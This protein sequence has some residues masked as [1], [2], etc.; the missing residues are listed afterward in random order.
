MRKKLKTTNWPRPVIQWGV[1]LFVLI[2]AFIPKFN[3]NF[4]PDFEAYCPFGGIQALGSYMLNQ[5]LSCTMT[6]AQ[7][8]MGLI[9][10]LA[11]LV[12]SKLF[13]AYVCPV[14]TISEW[15]TQLG[16][17]LNVNIT[18]KGVADKILRSLKYI[19]LF[20]TVYFTFKSNEL[21]CKKFDPYY[22]VSTGFSADVVVLYASIAIF[23]VILGSVFVRLFW[24]K[25][26][27]PFGAISNIFKFTGFFLIVLIG[28]ILLLKAGLA[29][30]YIWPL[31]I[32]CIG[33]YV[34]ELTGFASK[35][36]PLLK[37]TRNESSCIDCQLCS[38]KCPQAIDV[39][40][41]KVV[42]DVDCNLCV[43]CISVC[44]VKDTLQ[45]NKRTSY[46]WIPVIATVALFIVGIFIGT[47]WELPTIDQKWF[48]KEEMAKA[49]IFTQSGLRNIKCYGSSMAF[50]AQMKPVD[51]VLGVATYVKHNKV[52]VY[53]DP[54]KLTTA[55]I[56]ELLFT[57]A[58]T[59]LRP[60]K[61]GIEEVKE[62]TVYLDK[63]FDPFDFSYLS[64]LLTDNTAAVGLVTEF[65]CPVLVKI[66]FPGDYDISES[67]LTEVLQSKTLTFEVGESTKTV[68]LGY[69]VSKT[70]IFRK[71]SKDDYSSILYKPL[72]FQFNGYAK[73]KS[74]S[75]KILNL[76]MGQNR[77][78]KAK[79]NYLVSHLS[80][81]RGIIEFRTKL[82]EKNEELVAISYVDSLTNAQA[83]FQALNSDSLT[84]N[85]R[86]G[87][88]GKI[89]NVFKFE[90]EAELK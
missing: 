85:K 18:V 20:I 84:F 56:Q 9:T 79:L 71:I 75:V 14:G 29:I 69:T 10:M 3:S 44:P 30:H 46:R 87:S 70:P 74:A 49:E 54:K 63:F 61:K 47:L 36:F 16:E 23:L 33:G 73:Y 37:I 80:N 11:V 90:T 66:Y 86:D 62:V 59:A 15:L 13:C 17:K 12:F 76:A 34:I 42:R 68:D 72:L 78:N 38:Q 88:K 26:I 4:V 43:E 28:Y 58:R 6:T 22:A 81:N 64:R 55:K 40:N 24:C 25:Y 53:F 19:L 45:L 60:L 21:F 39:A 5:A 77:E 52:K 32:S 41:L 82:N 50:A 1:I 89:E 2:I 65:A 51:G 83:V 7:I 27:C 57:P 48:G 67:E 35:T 8:A 31:A